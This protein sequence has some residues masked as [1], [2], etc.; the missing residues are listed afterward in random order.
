MAEEK[1]TAKT[2]D[3]IKQLSQTVSSGDLMSASKNAKELRKRT[4]QLMAKAKAKLNEIAEEAKAAQVVEKSESV[5]MPSN[6]EI[7]KKTEKEVEKV[8][9]VI[10]KKEEPKNVEV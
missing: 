10:E 2:M 7:E 5:E 6:K 1:K 4:A 3:N 8:A 9:P